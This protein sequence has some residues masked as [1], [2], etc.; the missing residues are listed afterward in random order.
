MTRTMSGGLI[1]ALIGLAL[2]ATAGVV[3]ALDHVQGT[4]GGECT[5]PAEFRGKTAATLQIHS[6]RAG[7]N[8]A[9]PVIEL[10]RPICITV[11]GVGS[12]PA[13]PALRGQQQAAATSASTTAVELPPV[14]ASA[15][16]ATGEAAKPAEQKVEAPNA[17]PVPPTAAGPLAQSGLAT[18][19]NNV[20]L[21][22][23]IDG[24][25]TPARATAAAIAD[26]QPLRF[27]LTSANDARAD[28]AVRIRHILGGLL[29]GGSRDVSIGLGFHNASRPLV[30]WTPRDPAAN[31]QLRV[32]S[33]K[34]AGIAALGFIL[35]LVAIF[36]AGRTSSLLRD[37][38]ATSSYSLAR[39]QMAFWMIATVFGFV[40]I[41]V[42]THQYLNVITAS[43]FTLLGISGAT[44]LA[45]RAIDGGTAAPAAQ[46]KGFLIDIVSDADGPQLHRIQL[47]IWTIVLG[48]IFVWNVL[49][50]LVLTDF[51]P[52]LLILVG[53]ANGVYAGFKTQETPA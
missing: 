17:A 38:D 25:E 37:G 5:V 30:E 14:M 35:L 50:A 46:S 18:A 4:R 15:P 21:A 32:Y 39:A 19:T 27:E 31:V 53:I 51:D 49:D 43:S 29:K 7:S 52:N 12:S 36:L 2:I 34:R 9:V 26:A 6:I 20:E 23:Y 11:A 10:G 1:T 22:L 24:E 45:S 33:P 42:L 47:V 13:A 41:W 3:T 28:D 44:A 40:F 8:L 48:T 16:S